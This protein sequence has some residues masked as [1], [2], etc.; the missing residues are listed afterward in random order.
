MDIECVDGFAV[1]MKNSWIIVSLD[2]F[3]MEMVENDD[4]DDDKYLIHK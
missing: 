3:E 1:S 4:D 2:F